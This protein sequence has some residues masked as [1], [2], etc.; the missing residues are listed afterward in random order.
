[1]FG[2]LLLGVSRALLLVNRLGD[3][4]DDQADREHVD[5]HLFFVASQEVNFREVH[6]D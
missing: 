6:A 2:L 5:L 1:M 4:F 3:L